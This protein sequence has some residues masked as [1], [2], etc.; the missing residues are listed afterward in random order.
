MTFLPRPHIKIGDRVALEH[1]TDTLAG[2]FTRGHEFTVTNRTSRG[3]DLI[4]DE[5][6]R[7]LETNAKLRV[8]E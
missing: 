2:L 1:D 7:L 8:I 6:N 4:D 3:W 5:N